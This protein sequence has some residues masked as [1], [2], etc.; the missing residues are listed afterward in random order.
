MDKGG[1]ENSLYAQLQQRKCFVFTPKMLNLQVLSALKPNI[2]KLFYIINKENK[3]TSLSFIKFLKE[4]SIPYEILSDL[5]E[6][7]TNNLKLEYFDYGILIPVKEAFKKT[8]FKPETTEGLKFL[9]NRRIL[10]GGK[11][12]LSYE[13]LK[14]GISVDETGQ[15]AIIDSPEL[16][17]DSNFYYIYGKT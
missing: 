9:T 3:D 16:F 13:H 8:D 11:M 5:D 17:G 6:Q 4:Q 7:E 15:N 12:Y 2:A 1:Y 10:A 14:L